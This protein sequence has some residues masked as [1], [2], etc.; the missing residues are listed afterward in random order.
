M[1]YAVLGT[2][3]VGRT[4]AAKLASVGHEVAIGTRDPQ[5]TLARSEAD[6]M[7][8]PPFAHWHQDHPEVRLETFAD[9]TA[10]AD[11]VVNATSGAA[12]LD[13]L[14][15]A[16]AENLDGKLLLD[17]ANPL[18]FSQGMPPSLNPVNTDSLGE[19]IQRAFPGVKVV[20]TLNTMNSAVMVDPARVAGEHHVFVSGD[21]ADAKKAATE[22]LVS[23]GWP[24]AAVLDL[25]DIT[26]AR[27]TE[28]LLPIWL[29]LW[30]A[31]GHADFNFHIQGARAAS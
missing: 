19:Q 20:K 15:R 16:G 26:T 13:V 6:A 30:G 22:L 9:A 14:A 17:I 1:Q 31:L 28:M 25:G 2:G 29:R 12:A 23:F 8:T 11:A 10:S 3:V 5:A 4:I 18:D 27:G 24:A 7:G 21:D